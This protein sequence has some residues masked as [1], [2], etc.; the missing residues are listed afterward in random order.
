MAETTGKLSIAVYALP[1]L[2]KE[3]EKRVKDGAN[4]SLALSDAQEQLE[5]DGRTYA[6]H[7]QSG[8]FIEC[9]E[10]TDSI[11]E[12]TVTIVRTRRRALLEVPYSVLHFADEHPDSTREPRYKGKFPVDK[13]LEMLE[14]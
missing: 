13:L 14:A 1:S 11:P 10:C 12:G 3:I 6:I 5:K 8:K 7:E 4:Y 2:D 9:T